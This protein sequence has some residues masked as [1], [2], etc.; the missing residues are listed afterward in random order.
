MPDITDFHAH[1]Y[2]DADTFQQADQLCKRAGELFELRVGQ[3]L[4]RPVGPHPMWSCQLLFSPD[5][6]GELVP[7]LALNRHGLIVFVHPTTGD[8]LADHTAHAIWM[9][10]VCEL[11]LSVL[12]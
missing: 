6:F 1:V 2:F 8:D 4:N 11:D 12:S 5:L 3:M 7:W 10:E 9:G